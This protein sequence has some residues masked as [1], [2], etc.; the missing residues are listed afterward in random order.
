MT[1]RETGRE[2][3]YVVGRRR[4]GRRSRKRR[5]EGLRPAGRA[6]GGTCL[7]DTMI[8]ALLARVLFR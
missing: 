2:K 4:S 7:C 3:G 8:G 1:R 6:G 5:L